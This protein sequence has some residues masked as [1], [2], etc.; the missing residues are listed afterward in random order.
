M[1]VSVEAEVD[2]RD[3]MDQVFRVV[4]YNVVM[5]LILDSMEEST[6]P[7]VFPS[8]CYQ[9]IKQINARRNF[10]TFSVLRD[11]PAEQEGED[12]DDI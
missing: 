10:D 7:S 5:D 4:D 6:V 1:N 2:V 8:N 9:L 11:T 3:L 12:S